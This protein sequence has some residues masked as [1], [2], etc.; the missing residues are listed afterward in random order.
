M[1]PKDK[2]FSTKKTLNVKGQLINLTHPSV[3]GIL[4][5]T[6]DSFYDGNKYTCEQSLLRQVEK[7]IEEGAIII[8]VGAYSSR[9]G[10]THIS[11]EEEAKRVRKA[12]QAIT[13]S[14]REVILSIDTFRASIAK[15]AVEEGASI[16]N[17]ISGGAL[18][19]KMF[20]TVAALKVP[21]VLMH[22]RGTPQ[23]MLQHTHY[24]NLLVEMIT[25]FQKKVYQLMQWGVKDI[26]I[27]PGFG[28]AKTVTQNY[29]ILKNLNYLQVLQLPILIGISRKSMIYKML[30][31]GPAETLNGTSVLNT[32]GLMKGASI[33]RVHDVREA[34]EAINLVKST[35]N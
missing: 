9:P 34:T 7:M 26:I 28:F 31:R 6:P 30:G 25:Y 13:Q 16:V 33:L 15:L 22:M 8:D 17:D 24:D 20:K 19:Q 1:E 21:Y 11:E 12:L 27:D 10:A 2:F 23:N 14:F 18:D 5:V 29:K 4:N 3:M 35:F 32:L